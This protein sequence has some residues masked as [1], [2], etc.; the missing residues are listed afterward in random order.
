MFQPSCA[1]SLPARRPDRF[2]TPPPVAAAL[3]E[4]AA[5]TELTGWIA[6][7]AAG[8]GELL[9]AARARWRLA[10]VAATD[11]DPRVVKSLRTSFPDWH[12]QRQ[13]FFA[14]KVEQ[15]SL[16]ST[17]RGKVALVVL[18]P[19][20]SHRGPSRAIVTLDGIE[21]G[22]SLGLAFIIRALPYLAEDGELL[23]I[24]PRGSLHAQRDEQAWATLRARHA[25]TVV[26]TNSHKTF[27]GCTAYTVMVRFGVR[28]ST[29]RVR[30]PIQ[31]IIMRRR[32]GAVRLIRGGVSMCDSV[33]K[34][35]A[36]VLPL[37][38][39]T[40]LRHGTVDVGKRVVANYLHTVCGPGV[41]IPR[42]GKPNIEKLCLLMQRKPIVLSDCVLFVKCQTNSAART[43][44]QYLTRRWSALE[45]LYGGTCA[46]YLTLRA[47]ATVLGDL[48][49]HVQVMPPK[50][51]HKGVGNASVSKAVRRK[52]TKSTSTI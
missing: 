32:C 21:L 31:R 4:H 8:G 13:D 26:G 7:F 51:Q 35:V 25:V 34:N 11:I 29:S 19:P 38:H 12:V 18:N 33:I 23:S 48:G 45:A 2:Y 44:L 42:V 3:I 41:L 10:R 50:V 39:T 14:D 5:L 47:L 37:V 30:R 52:T 36:P 16:L 28:T 9:K 46:R 22:C 43:V 27:E 17:I 24:V 40:E 6:D 1:A 15:G 20:F 49:V